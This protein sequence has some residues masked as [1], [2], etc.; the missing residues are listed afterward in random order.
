MTRQPL[1]L[2]SN[3][4]P[5]SAYA[6]RARPS[7]TRHW[8][9]RTAWLLTATATRLNKLLLFLPPALVAEPR[10]P[11]SARTLEQRAIDGVCN[12]AV[13]EFSSEQSGGRASGLQF[14]LRDLNTRTSLPISLCRAEA[15]AGNHLAVAYLL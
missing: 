12:S 14:C 8:L 15:K 11:S 13:L 6:A 7:I 2:S 5:M 10:C 4:L 3:H 1:W 9:C